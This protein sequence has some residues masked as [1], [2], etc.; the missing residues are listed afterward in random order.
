MQLSFSAHIPYWKGKY[1][2]QTIVLF[3]KFVM[4]QIYIQIEGCYPKKSTDINLVPCEM[5]L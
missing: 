5:Y 3:T 1:L 4:F 2:N